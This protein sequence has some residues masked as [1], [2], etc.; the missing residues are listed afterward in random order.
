MR[1]LIIPLMFIFALSLLA[2]S[3]LASTYE[4]TG[5]N[6]TETL[7]TYANPLND[8]LYF[9]LS[10]G[11]ARFINMS[12]N[13]SFVTCKFMWN[14]N[15][16]Y[17]FLK[18]NSYANTTWI[19]ASSYTFF[20]NNPGSW[21]N[22]TFW[23]NNGTNNM[24]YTNSST[25]KYKM[26][27]ST[28]YT[29]SNWIINNYSGYASMP[30]LNITTSRSVKECYM[31]NDTFSTIGMKNL[32]VHNHTDGS[33]ESQFWGNASSLINIPSSLFGDYHNITFW[34]TDAYGNKTW[35]NTSKTNLVN[36]FLDKAKS[37]FPGN[38]SWSL[39][40]YTGGN[41]VQLWFNISDNNP[42]KCWAG[43]HYYKD[44]TIKNTTGTASYDTSLS[45]GTTGLANCSINIT[46][47]DI[48]KD[49]Y[50]EIFGYA[51]DAVGNQNKT[52]TNRSYI[53]YRMKTG[54]N[55]VTGFEN[56]TLNQIAGEFTNVSY[57]SVWDE[58][59]KT[60]TTF[61]VGGATNSGILANFSSV[62]GAGAT[63]IY[64]TEDI[65]SMRRYYA[66]PTTWANV[67]LYANATTGKTSWNMVGINRNITNL[68]MTLINQSACRNY[69]YTITNDSLNFTDNGTF[70]P[71]TNKNVTTV[72]LVSNL[73]LTVPALNYSYNT[74][75]IN[76]TDP[77]GILGY[78]FN[79]TFNV[80]YLRAISWADTSC[81]D[82]TWVS[83]YNIQ[84]GKYC[85]FYY[86]RLATS[87]SGY[88]SNN[89]S[90][91]KGDALWIALREGVNVTLDRSK[92]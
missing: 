66:I 43:L 13:V 83:W 67:T 16:T 36:Y 9:N 71:F 63:Y 53:V 81:S 72:I 59:N 19:N 55:M 54:W 3:G 18:N 6:N 88:L 38:L 27:S 61:T 60:F 75:H 70:I 64:V 85:S 56:K 91:D 76:I 52:D 39:G 90:L 24:T 17:F 21:N 34:C 7:F 45:V 77:N 22:F 69:T 49:G 1:R 47:S 78:K 31:L 58:L 2:C 4:T 10:T 35:L 41:Y 26:F 33:T 80:T 57:V 68:N 14:N 23:C 79:R 12:T 15:Q 28:S 32:T 25:L 86:N 89:I 65:V 11:Y 8:T 46:P 82:F 50:V 74:T 87:C 42:S 5:T 29:I 37:T 92:W 84:L 48:T 20:D 44:N 30:L 51:M 40:N 62:Y 73:S